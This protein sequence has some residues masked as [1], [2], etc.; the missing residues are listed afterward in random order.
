MSISVNNGEA[1]YYEINQQLPASYL[2]YLRTISLHVDNID[3]IMINKTIHLRNKIST[4]INIGRIMSAMAFYSIPFPP[5][6]NLMMYSGLSL[7]FAFENDSF[8][9]IN[10]LFQDKKIIHKVYAFELLDD[11]SGYI[12]FGGIPDNVVTN[13]YKGKCHI[14]KDK[15]SCSLGRLYF[16]NDK[17]YAKYYVNENKEY[18]IAYFNSGYDSLIA[19][20][21]YMNFLKDTLFRDKLANGD[22]QYEILGLL[23]VLGFKCK[24]NVHFS[25]MMFEIEDKVHKIPKEV[26]FYTY[27]EKEGKY[28]FFS[29]RKFK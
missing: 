14:I 11:I 10:K 25:Y 13:K 7:A 12:Y 20:S 6:Y 3:E 24:D 22:C 21:T 16:K 1:T 15:W 8:S 5:S 18:P 19:P 17:S 9:L 29:S 26:L 23:Y 4:I 27:R 2:N 28:F